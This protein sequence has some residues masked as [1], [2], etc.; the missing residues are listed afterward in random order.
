MSEA[1]KVIQ[2]NKPKYKTPRRGGSYLKA[3]DDSNAPVLISATGVDLDTAQKSA[4]G[5]ERDK[6]AQAETAGKKPANKDS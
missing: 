3:A 5:K 4:L 6:A 1:K 2:P